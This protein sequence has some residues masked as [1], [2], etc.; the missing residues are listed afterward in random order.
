MVAV[1]APVLHKYV[2]PPLAVRVALNPVHMVWGD[3]ALA[4]GSGFTVMILE[5]DA[6]QPDALVTVTV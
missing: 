1:V 4:T 2:P 3:P 6:V 5:A